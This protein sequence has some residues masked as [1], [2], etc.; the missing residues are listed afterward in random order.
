MNSPKIY[1]QYAYYPSNLSQE[2]ASHNCPPAIGA[3]IPIELTINVE[4]AAPA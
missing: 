4:S 1:V 2:S 3:I